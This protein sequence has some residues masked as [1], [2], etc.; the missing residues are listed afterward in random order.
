MPVTALEKSWSLLAL[1]GSPVMVPTERARPSLVFEAKDQR[2][3]GMAGVNRFGGPY[4][5]DTGMLKLGPLL[6]TKMAGPPE[7]NELE[8]RYLRTLERTAGWRINGT[9]L[10]LLAGDRVLARFAVKQ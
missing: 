4:K 3:S 7:L 9:D 5:A 2:V 6:A 10:E 8:T 1:D